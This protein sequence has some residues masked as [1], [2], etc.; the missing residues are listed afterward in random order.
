MDNKLRCK[1]C[2][3]IAYVNYFK[4]RERCT[5]DYYKKSPLPPLEMCIS[6]NHDGR[7]GDYK[8]KWWKFWR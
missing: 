4:F 5:K 3:F 6:K 2:K 7:C 1:D 8:R